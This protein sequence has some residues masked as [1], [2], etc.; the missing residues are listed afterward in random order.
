MKGKMTWVSP[1]NIA[2]IKYWGKK[3]NQI[4][5]NPSISFTLKDSVTTTSCEWEESDSSQFELRFEGNRNEK[6][7][8]RVGKYLDSLNK[9]LPFLKRL[10]LIFDTKNTFPHSAGIASSASSFSSFA[11]ILTQLETLLEGKNYSEREFMDRASYLARL[12]SGSACRS[13][14]GP[15]CAWRD[16]LL[17]EPVETHEIFKSYR[18]TIVIIDQGTKAVSSSQGHALMN[19][20]PFATHRYEMAQD[21]FKKVCEIL[22]T[23]DAHALG[24]ILEHEAL[25]LHGLMMSSPTPY[26]LMKPSTIEVIDKVKTFRRDHKVPLYF[27]LDA[28]PNVHLLYPKEY[29]P[30][31]TIFIQNNFKQYGLIFDQVGSGPKLK[32]SEVY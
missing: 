15:V 32:E 13:V 24:K 27:T 21:H 1:S 12:G 3:P 4:P 28:G 16:D 18:D 31:V 8:Q 30:Q 17:G 11:L 9:E 25:T 22:K 5:C 6:F 20:H 26:I 10:H 29:E 23:G 19:S 7:E 14:F 2:L